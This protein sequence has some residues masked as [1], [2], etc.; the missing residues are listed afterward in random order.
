MSAISEVGPR[1]ATVMQ[2]VRSLIVASKVIGN[3]EKADLK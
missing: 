3:E 1:A 2:T